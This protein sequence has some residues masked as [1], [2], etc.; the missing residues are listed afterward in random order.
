METMIFY[1]ALNHEEACALK[2]S[3]V[4]IKKKPRLFGF[5]LQHRLAYLLAHRCDY[6]YKLPPDMFFSTALFRF[7][8]TVAGVR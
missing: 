3:A 2:I 1:L 6:P 8:A 5:R 7:G 4:S